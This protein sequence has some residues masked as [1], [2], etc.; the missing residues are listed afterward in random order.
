MNTAPA[1]EMDYAELRRRARER[2]ERSRLF[3]RAQEHLRAT[4]G[5]IYK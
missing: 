2:D 4:G 3:N 1:Q 5:G